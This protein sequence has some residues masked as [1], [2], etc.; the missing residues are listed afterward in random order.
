MEN[1]KEDRTSGAQDMSNDEVMSQFNIK[2]TVTECNHGHAACSHESNH[3]SCKPS[4][5]EKAEKTTTANEQNSAVDST[6]CMEL[7]DFQKIQSK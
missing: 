5:T 6:D 4:S 1:S 7:T 3:D 2:D